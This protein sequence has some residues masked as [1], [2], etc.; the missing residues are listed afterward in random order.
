MKTSRGGY[1]KSKTKVR[2]RI[3]AMCLI[4]MFL[5]IPLLSSPVAAGAHT[6]AAGTGTSTNTNPPAVCTVAITMTGPLATPAGA[7]PNTLT[8]TF[9]YNFVDSNAGPAGSKHICNMRVTEPTSGTNRLVSTGWITVAAGATVSG[10]L[11]TGPFGFAA[12]PPT[13]VFTIYVNMTVVDL[14]TGPPRSGFGWGSTTRTF[15]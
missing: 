15:T 10:T 11:T 4:A 7:P 14:N 9:N 12:T 5:L 13:L 1:M 6:F 3:G 8:V 2:F